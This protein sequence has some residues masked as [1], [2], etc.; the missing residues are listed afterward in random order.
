MAFDEFPKIDRYSL[1]SDES[2]IAL[3]HLLNK[4]TGFILRVDLPDLGCDFDVELVRNG[5][6]ASNW[7]FPIQ[8]KGVETIRRIDDGQFISY[9]FATSRLGYLLRRLPAYGL[10]ILYDLPSKKLYYDYADEIYKRLMERRGNDHWKGNDDVSILIPSGNVL[11]PE[12]VD[13]LHRKF[14]SRFESAT[15]MQSSQG[16][17]Y[18]LPEVSLESGQAFDVNNLEHV[19][20]VLRKWGT[21]MIMQFD[22]QTVYGLLTRLPAEQIMADRELCMLALTT[23]AE[24]GRNADSIFYTQRARKRFELTQQERRTMDFIGLKN[25]LYLGEI[26]TV[27]YIEGT[28]ALLPTLSQ[29]DSITLRVQLLYFE[30]SLVQ[31]LEPMPMHLGDQ[32]QQLFKEIDDAPLQEVWKQYLKVWNAQNM[33][34]WIAHFRIEGFAE[35]QIREHLGQP[36]PPLVLQ[37]RQKTL[38]KVHRMFYFFVAGIDAFAQKTDNALLQAHL[39]RIVV[40]FEFNFAEQ[41]VRFVAPDDGAGDLSEHVRIAD[42]AYNVFLESKLFREAYEVLLMQIDL[43]HVARYWQETVAGFDI[44]E[45][46]KRKD[47]LEKQHELAERLIIPDLLKKRASMEKETLLE[48]LNLRSYNDAQFATLARIVFESGKFPRAW[49][50]HILGWM[51]SYRLFH[52]RC[53]SDEIELV[54]VPV[55]PDEAFASPVAFTFRNRSTNIVSLVSTDMEGLLQS[56]G[57]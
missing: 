44:G 21:T 30:I 31:W 7:R 53:K 4:K 18:G 43:L 27:Q 40:R 16:A 11:T 54:E 23:Y 55:A 6:S 37:E 26:S 52:Q 24:S 50:E 28:R 17:K 34:R 39:F 49:L 33:E 47:D 29:T 48:I 41:K 3:Q 5:D 12:S 56:W 57:Y 38:L 14:L 51:K 32:V 35:G 22:L 45:L 36:L 46:M 42:V 1:N 20:Q 10:L 13:S 8:L 19:K 25:R 2:V 9:P 15:L